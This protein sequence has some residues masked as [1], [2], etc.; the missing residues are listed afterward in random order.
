M[1]FKKV[2]VMLTISKQIKPVGPASFY[3]AAWRNLVENHLEYLR[4]HPATQKVDLKDNSG[5]HF[6]GDFFGLLNYAGIPPEYHWA[7]MRVNNYNSTA[8]FKENT[9]FFIVPDPIELNRLN[10]FVAT[11]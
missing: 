6:R 7:I 1:F 10:K 3:T 11:A 4:T 2:P 5:Y 8:E 9:L